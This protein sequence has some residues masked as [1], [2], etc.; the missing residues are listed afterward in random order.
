MWKRFRGRRKAFCAEAFRAPS[1]EPEPP[2]RDPPTSGSDER[3]VDPEDGRAKT[4]RV[5]G[6]E[7]NRYPFKI[8]LDMVFNLRIFC[9]YS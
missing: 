3:R 1:P 2:R 6:P 8:N 7:R 4:F 5:E 9:L